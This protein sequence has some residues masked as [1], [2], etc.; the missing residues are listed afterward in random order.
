MR[1]E[2]K[3]LRSF[4]QYL[5]VAVVLVCISNETERKSPALAL[6]ISMGVPLTIPFLDGF[7]QFYNGESPKGVE[8]MAWSLLSAGA[9]FSTQGVSDME[10]ETAAT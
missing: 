4:V 1:F 10:D 3:Y 8:F 2:Q 7:G 9:A 6:G 5:L